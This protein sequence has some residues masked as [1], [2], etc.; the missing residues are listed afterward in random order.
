MINIYFRYRF[1]CF[2]F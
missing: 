2:C 1:N